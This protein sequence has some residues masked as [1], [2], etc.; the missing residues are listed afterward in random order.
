L[1]EG[2]YSPQSWGS[3]IQD[4]YGSAIFLSGGYCHASRLLQTLRGYFKDQQILI[5]EEFDYHALELK[6]GQAHWR[7][8]AFKQVI[9]CEGHQAQSNPWFSWLPFNHAKGEILH[10]EIKDTALPPMILSQS[11]WCVPIA[12]G[13]WL[14]GANY[15]RDEFNAMPSAAG[16][17]EIL[18]GLNEFI[19]AEKTVI[20]H[21]AA[22]RPVLIDQ[23]PVLGLH[24]KHPCLA[25]FNGLA[26]K[27][28]LMAPYY[29][30]AFADFLTQGTKIDNRV[31]IA[32]FYRI[33]Q[34]LPAQLVK[35]KRGYEKHPVKKGEFDVFTD[36]QAWGE[37]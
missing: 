20:A 24:P 15:N 30:D 27:G 12:A 32:R 37:V 21:Y 31:D 34:T 18:N 13:Q 4:P 19:T 16:R 7:G 23:M 2:I 11:K 17:Q 14:A 6:G 9:F 1:I 33:K 10:L 22:V 26:S 35:H 5:E 3:G 25:I 29:A 28:F 8:E 36:E